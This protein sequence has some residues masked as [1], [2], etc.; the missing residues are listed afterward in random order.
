MSVTLIYVTN[1]ETNKLSISLSMADE[2]FEAFEEWCEA[3]DLY[4]QNFEFDEDMCTW[5]N[6]LY[7]IEV[8]WEDSFTQIYVEK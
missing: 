1:K 8:I 2:H 3:N 4:P 7:D 6:E 5:S